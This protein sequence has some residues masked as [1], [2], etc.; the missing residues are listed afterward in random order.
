MVDVYSDT[1]DEGRIYHGAT[2]ANQLGTWVFSLPVVGPNITATATVGGATTSEF[3]A[4]V[5][6]PVVSFQ[7]FQGATGQVWT[8]NPVPLASLGAFNSARTFN[9]VTALVRW[10]NTTQ[11]FQFWEGNPRTTAQLDDAPTVGLPAAVTAVFFWANGL[12]QF[13]FWFRGFPDPFQ[14]LTPGLIHGGFY[15]FQAAQANVPVPMN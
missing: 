14:T 8:G 12:Q 11:Q 4:P 6:A 15:F 9:V 1:V 5:V 2:T 3:S 10:E 7:L 13:Q